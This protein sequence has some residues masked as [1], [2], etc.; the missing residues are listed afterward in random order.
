VQPKPGG[1]YLVWGDADNG[2]SVVVFDSATQQWTY[3]EFSYTPGSMYGMRGRENLDAS[4]DLWMLRFVAFN[5]GNPVY[6]LDYRRP[7]GSWVTPAQP[8]VPGG[9]LDIAAFR[10]FDDRQALLAEGNGRIW[11]YD[12]AA[13]LDLGIWRSGDYTYDLEMDAAGNVWACGTGGAARRDAE[14]GQW[15]R[16]RVTNTSQYDSFNA[17]LTL[18]PATGRL[19]ACANAGPGFGG[20]TH[21]DGT[22][23]IGFN[24]YTYGLGVDWPFPDFC[25]LRSA[26]REATQRMVLLR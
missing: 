12:G 2:A 11:R 23:W 10:A 25:K 15:Q 3:N 1:G 6:S 20:A 8:P 17:D 19:W 22:R 4:G 9:A 24:N 5:G 14:T 21:F 16:Y 7:D 18:D 13:W 26:G